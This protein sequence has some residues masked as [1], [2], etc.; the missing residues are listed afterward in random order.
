MH[1]GQGI[2][3]I[4]T[5]LTNIKDQDFVLFECVNKVGPTEDVVETLLAYGLHL[6]SRYRFSKSDDHGNGQIWDFRQVR[7]QLLQFRDRLETFLGQVL[8]A[9][10][11][12]ISHYAHQ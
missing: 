3:E 6:T 12:Q 10:I 11:Q 7:L 5:L 4:N 8:C 9:G 2:N 1:S